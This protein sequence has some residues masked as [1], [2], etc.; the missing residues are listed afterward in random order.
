MP[1]VV[2]ELAVKHAEDAEPAA[3]WRSRLSSSLDDLRSG[4]AESFAPLQI[5]VSNFI[6]SITLVGSTQGQRH[7]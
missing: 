6:R 5:K 7:A 4:D 1:H 3:L 2:Q